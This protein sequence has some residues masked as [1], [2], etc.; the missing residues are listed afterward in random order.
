M[1]WPRPLFSVCTWALRLRAQSCLSTVVVVAIFSISVFLP[2]HGP[3]PP[4]CFNG[5]QDRPRPPNHI[6]NTFVTNLRPR[7]GGVTIFCEESGSGNGDD[8]EDDDVTL[9]DSPGTQKKNRCSATFVG[10][11]IGRGVNWG[12]K[13]RYP[14]LKPLQTNQ[15]TEIVTAQSFNRRFF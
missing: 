8:A 7:F 15:T 9:L 14:Y 4:T 1:G 5:P 13:A 10:G 11:G 2:L 6:K 12:E 3:G